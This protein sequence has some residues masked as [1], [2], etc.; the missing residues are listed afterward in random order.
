M[1]KEA[2]FTYRLNYWIDERQ[3]SKLDETAGK[4]GLSRSD[5][6]R[7]AMLEGLE[8]FRGACLPGSPTWPQE[9]NSK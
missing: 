7:R 5:V 3:L 6:A 8:K 9:G 4:L 2:V 1:T